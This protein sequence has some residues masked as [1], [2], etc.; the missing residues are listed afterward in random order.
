MANLYLN[1]TKKPT[2]LRSLINEQLND[3]EIAPFASEVLTAK[4]WY[5]GKDAGAMEQIFADMVS[6]VGMGAEDK[7][8]QMALNEAARKIQQTY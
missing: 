3:M 1:K 7:E 2:A 6:S 8:Y 4:S 5:K